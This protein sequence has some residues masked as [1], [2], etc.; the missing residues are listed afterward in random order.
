MVQVEP[1]IS[2]QTTI[3]KPDG[4]G[5][6]PIIIMNHGKDPIPPSMQHRV[7]YR[8]FSEEF[9]K[10]GYAII[11]PMRRGF[12]KSTGSFADAGCNLELTGLLQAEDIKLTIEHFSK[13][14][15]FDSSRIVVVGQSFGG[16][17]T[18][19]FGSIN[20]PGVRGT[21]NFAGGLKFPLGICRWKEKL[22][23]A[24]RDYGKTSTVPSLWFYGKTDQYFDPPLASAMYEAY[25]GEG[26]KA[27]LVNKFDYPYTS[28]SHMMIGWSDGVKFWWP[29]TEKFL[30]EIN[31]PIE[32]KND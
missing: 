24:M 15:W 14:P 18:V 29:E 2:L 16:L 21:I 22:I 20:F 30:K 19:A 5:P 25:T 12:A 10:R 28:D 6:F 3:I 9:L 31:M 4:P 17:A 23:T 11:L 27:K 13:E 8:I 1:K 7:T 26:A 32:I